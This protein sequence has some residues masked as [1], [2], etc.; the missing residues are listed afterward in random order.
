MYFLLFMGGIGEVGR[1]YVAYVYNVEMVP[2][3]RQNDTGL[4]IFL[5]FGFA[6]TYIAL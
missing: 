2:Q 6:M 3:K 1:Y 5:V 4:F